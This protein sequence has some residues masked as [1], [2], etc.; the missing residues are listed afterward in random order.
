MS[1]ALLAAIAAGCAS[2]IE[3]SAALPVRHAVVLDQLVIHSDSRLA[4]QDRLFDELRALREALSAT[5]ALQLSKEPIHV[6]LF[7]N[8]KRFKAF[9]AKHYPEFP[10]R[11]AFFVQQ[12]NSLAV[13]AH[14]GDRVAEDLRHEVTHGYLHASFPSLP[15]WLDEG[16][17]EYFETPRGDAGLNRP[18]VTLLNTLMTRDGWRPNL[19]R[20]EQITSA[21]DMKQADYAECW[22][23]MHMLL[24]TIPQRRELVQDFLRTIRRDGPPEPLSTVVARSM[25]HPDQVLVD[26][27]TQLGKSQGTN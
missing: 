6:Y 22:A 16:L 18:H 9:L 27:L 25:P 3:R 10:D 5:L 20:L 13:Y 12:E 14:R 7:E 26:H 1:G 21:S 15:L 17:A 2:V 24:E 11:R 8:E 4:K 19:T 23:W